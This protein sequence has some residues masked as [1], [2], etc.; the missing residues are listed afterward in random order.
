M[1]VLLALQEVASR[2]LDLC[3]KLGFIVL[4]LK[5]W[6]MHKRTCCI[7]RNRRK[8]RSEDGMHSDN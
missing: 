3:T 6:A 7:N 4:R 8:S 1:T 2:C 5:A